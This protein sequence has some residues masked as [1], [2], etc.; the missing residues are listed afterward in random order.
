M[1][2]LIAGCGYVGV[3]LGRELTLQGREVWGL[4]RTRDSEAL[5]TS[6]GIKPLFADVKVEPKP[7]TVTE[8]VEMPGEPMRTEISTRASPLLD[9]ASVPPDVTKAWGEWSRLPTLTLS[10]PPLLMIVLFPG[11]ILTGSV[12]PMLSVAPV[13]VK[14]SPPEAF[15]I[16]N[17]AGLTTRSKVTVPADKV[18]SLRS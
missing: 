16:N 18:M 9:I 14:F 2:V 15:W 1:R 12:L 11:V 13:I 5:L 10:V 4:R 17:V 8:A 6:A 3:A 7:A